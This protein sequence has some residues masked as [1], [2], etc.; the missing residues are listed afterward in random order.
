ML[1]SR[2][3][4]PFSLYR[5]SVSAAATTSPSPL[6]SSSPSFPLA[7]SSPLCAPNNFYRHYYYNNKHENMASS[8][9]SSSPPPRAPGA[10]GAPETAQ[11]SPR[12]GL[13]ID[14]E[15]MSQSTTFPAFHAVTRCSASATSPEK[16]AASPFNFQPMVASKSPIIPNPVSKRMQ[17]ISSSGS[18]F[19]EGGGTD[20]PIPIAREVEGG[21]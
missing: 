7:P 18:S 21:G 4:P 1:K 5:D 3:L 16:P 11:V 10:S 17:P 15:T 2:G 19:H 9:P 12:T 14:S 8:S 6:T 20:I 13:G